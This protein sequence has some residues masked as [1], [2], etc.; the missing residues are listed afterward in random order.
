[1]VMEQFTIFFFG[2]GQEK[3]E[4]KKESGILGQKTCF[5]GKSVFFF[6]GASG[7]YFGS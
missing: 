3:M 5:V 2:W 4:E 7:W 6:K 1:M